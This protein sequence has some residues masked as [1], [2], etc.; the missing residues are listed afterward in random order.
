MM[1]MMKI[2]MKMIKKIIMSKMRRE[3]KFGIISK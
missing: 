1:K 3:L 2:S